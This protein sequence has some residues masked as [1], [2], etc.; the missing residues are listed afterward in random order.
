[1]R[2]RLSVGLLRL[3]HA[4]LFEYWNDP[5]RSELLTL[6]EQAAIHSDSVESERAERISNLRHRLFDAQKAARAERKRHA[7]ELRTIYASTSWRLI[8]PLRRLAN[9]VRRLIRAK[10]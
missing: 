5:V 3:F 10:P 2:P 4:C 8:A 6:V 1:M 7:R 9:M